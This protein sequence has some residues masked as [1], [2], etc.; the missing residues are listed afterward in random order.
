MNDVEVEK[1]LLE[2]STLSKG[3]LAALAEIRHKYADD[4]EV[5]AD[6]ERVLGI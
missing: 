5:V 4:P 1:E 2:Y 6:F 3:Q